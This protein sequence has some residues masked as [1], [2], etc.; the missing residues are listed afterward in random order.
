MKTW[1]K[2][3]GYIHTIDY[4]IA[5][6][7]YM[8]GVDL[9][10]WKN[11]HIILLNDLHII[12]LNGLYNNVI[13]FCTIFK[14][15]KENPKRNITKFWQLYLNEIIFSDFF[16]LCLPIFNL[17]M[18]FKL[19]Q[20][21]ILNKFILTFV[22]NI[23]DFPIPFHSLWFGRQELFISPSQLLFTVTLWTKTNN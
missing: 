4:H 22:L 7:N 17:Q 2:L 14:S 6:K 3:H 5:T 19:H 23:L 10:A 12:L 21:V 8:L 9:S 16:S 13:I 20:F 15:I 1:L 18:Y 11:L